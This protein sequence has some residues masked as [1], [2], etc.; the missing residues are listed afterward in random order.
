[1]QET[2]N[3]LASV[4]RAAFLTAV[5]AERERLLTEYERDPAALK[6]RLGIPLG[7]DMPARGGLLGLFRSRR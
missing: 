7:V 3:C 2:A 4:E 1:M 5:E 6:E